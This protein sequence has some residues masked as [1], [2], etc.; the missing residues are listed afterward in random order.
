MTRQELQ[1]VL[2][3]LSQKIYD[4][5]GDALDKIILYGSYARGDNSA[6]SDVDIIVLVDMDAAELKAARRRLN[7]IFSRVGLQHD[8]LLSLVLKNRTDFYHGLKVLPF[9]QNIIRDG[10]VIYAA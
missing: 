8:L 4:A 7:L 10:V 3:D 1:E 2:E 5:L 6:D 9:Y